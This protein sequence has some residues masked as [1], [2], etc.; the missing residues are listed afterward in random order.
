MAPAKSEAIFFHDRT[1]GE[2]SRATIVVDDIRIPVGPNLKYLGLTLD[3]RWG[4]VDHFDKIAPRLSRWADALLG[5]MPNLRGLTD[6]GV[7]RT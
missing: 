5:L 3:S 2:P 7:R 6:N 1:G 4:F